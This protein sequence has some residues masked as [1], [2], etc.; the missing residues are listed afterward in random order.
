MTKGEKLEQRYDYRISWTIKDMFQG[1]EIKDGYDHRISWTTKDMFQ[2]GEI[3]DR[4]G[5]GSNTKRKDDGSKFLDKS[6][7]H[8]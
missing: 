2:G 7:A 4:H 1:G 6:K 5:Q 8:K 3:K